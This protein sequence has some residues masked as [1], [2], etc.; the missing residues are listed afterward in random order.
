MPGGG[1]SHE[2][3]GIM[4]PEKAGNVTHFFAAIRIEALLPFDQFRGAVNAL[5]AFLRASPKAANVERIWM[6]GEIEFER[7]QE[8]RKEGIPLLPERY[9]ELSEL[10][11]RF[12]IPE[13]ETLS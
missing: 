13:M 7:E 6:P 4:N 12:G 5:C 3:I 8:H 2:I 10:A 1:H 11:K 9:A